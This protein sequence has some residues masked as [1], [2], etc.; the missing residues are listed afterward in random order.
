MSNNSCHLTESE[1]DTIFILRAVIASVG[2]LTNIIAISILLWFKSYKV[3][4][5]RVLLYL[6]I[7]NMLQV[8]VQC[9]E[10]A[11]VEN[12]HQDYNQ[13][14]H[15]WMPACRA[16]G[17][18]D[19]VTAWMGNFVIVWIV[20]YLLYLIRGTKMLKFTPL[21]RRE[22]VGIGVCFLFP[23]VFNWIPFIHNYYGLSGSWCWIKL[24]RKRCND[25][26]ITT[27]LGYMTGMYYLPLTIILCVNTL[28]CAVIICTW[29]QRRSHMKEVIFAIIYPLVYDAL[30]IVITVNRI[31][32]FVHIKRGEKVSY[33]FLVA[34]SIADPAR[35][36][37][38]SLLVIV[39]W[40]FPMTRKL[41]KNL[42]DKEYK[43]LLQDTSTKEYT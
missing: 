4:F 15:G 1:Q 19:Q 43:H 23:F 22:L 32:S 42:K 24:T 33:P 20:F 6:L 30:C 36:L 16:L 9:V 37:F 38:P 17:F 14:K 5:F 11:P 18:M 13:V 34:H 27:G 3:R 29:W 2:C 35:I 8:F 25:T 39:Q 21:S 28:A 7:A 26:D 41:M 31:S 40:V 12:N 10:L